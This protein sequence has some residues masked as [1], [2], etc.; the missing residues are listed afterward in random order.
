M[1]NGKNSLKSKGF[2]LIEL[3][4]VAFILSLIAVSTAPLLL[5]GVNESLSQ[6]RKNEFLKAYQNTMTGAQ[7][8]IT[9]A[10]NY[11]GIW[12]C[13]LLYYIKMEKKTM[14]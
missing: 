4:L 8:M 10:N 3:L 1:K 7:M 11:N 6:A 5:D 13:I 9:L 12:M 2:T 14:E